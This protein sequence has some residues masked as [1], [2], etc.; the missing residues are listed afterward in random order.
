MLARHIQQ[1]PDRPPAGHSPTLQQ[2][3]HNLVRPMVQPVLRVATAEDLQ[4]VLEFGAAVFCSHE[5]MCQALRPTLAEFVS[6][7]APLV[8]E[9]CTSG[10]SY[11]LELQEDEDTSSTC[12][13]IGISCCPQHLGIGLS[14]VGG[15]AVVIITAGWYFPCLLD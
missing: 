8:E 5:P 12:K 9:C 11:L 7:F 15:G 3:Q 13:L 10:L 4:R 2:F 1:P 6:Q 14:G